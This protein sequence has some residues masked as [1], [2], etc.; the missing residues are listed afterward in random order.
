M[1]ARKVGEDAKGRPDPP[2]RQRQARA[3][4][5]RRLREEYAPARGRLHAEG[6]D[7]GEG[8]EDQG[9][10]AGV[11]DT[12]QEVEGDPEAELQSLGGP[13][14]KSLRGVN[15]PGERAITH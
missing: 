12:V 9:I 5:G 13:A 10:D 4:R 8:G 2:S 1:L 7:P 3:E 15:Q 14:P 6:A 11:L